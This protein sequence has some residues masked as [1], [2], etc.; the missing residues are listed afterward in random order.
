MKRIVVLGGGFGGLAA[1][2]HLDR[3][4]RHDD[5]VEIELVSDSNYV[6]YTPMLADVA[7]G[8]IEP[9]HAVPPL[10]G[11][12]KKA[13]LREARVT[14][15]DVS[16]KI[17]HGTHLDGSAGELPYDYLVIALGSVTNFA[18]A[19]GAAEHSFGLKDLFDA[20]SLRNRALTMLEWANTVRDPELRQ[21]LL[22]FVVAG[23]GY[24]G[25]EGIAALEDM[26]HGAL[27][28]Y[29]SIR[30]EELRFILAPHGS[31]LL[32]QVDERLG[33]YV[34]EKFSRRSIDVRLGVGVNAVTARS[35]T[36]TTGE[37]IPTRTVIWTGGIMVNPALREVALPKDHHGALQV[38]GRLQVIDHPTIFA[39]GDCAAVPLPDGKG[40]YAP[41]A[42]NAIREGPVAAA[43][44]SALLRHSASLK[45]FEYKPIGSLASLGRRQ[46]VAQI[47]NMRLSGLLAWLAWRGIYLAKL[48]T[49]GEKIRVGLDWTVN[50][51]A[52]VDTAQLPIIRENLAS[53]MARKDISSPAPDAS[54]STP[55]DQPASVTSSTSGAPEHS[56]P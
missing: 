29:H 32:A 37:V 53:A 55:A 50:M 38:N 23:G 2:Q 27:R 31:R 51:F 54:A 17:V 49:L 43:N 35:A 47:G 1:A 14:G 28:Y 36:L 40:F 56:R 42:Q 6:V 21:E 15:I 45:A 19:T 48:P 30:P 41:T 26:L 7:G 39:L 25:V 18:H 9:R 34:V 44:V 46:A 3:A 10:R 33:D 5:D 24:S 4:F 16:S 22:T 20:V 11:F 12:L 52:P 13:H 8:T